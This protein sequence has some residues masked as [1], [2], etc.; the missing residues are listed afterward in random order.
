MRPSNWNQVPG[1]PP[2]PELPN[3]P[4]AIEEWVSELIKSGE[5]LETAQGVEERQYRWGIWDGVLRASLQMEVEVT[6]IRFLE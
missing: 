5:L 2:I 6:G 4:R 3:D 1:G